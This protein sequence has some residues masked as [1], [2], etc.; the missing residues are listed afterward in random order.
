M[1]TPSSSTTGAS[2]PQ[3]EHV[4]TSP[5]QVRVLRIDPSSR[6]S[7]ALRLLNG[8][9]QRRW[10]QR[11][12][13]DDRERRT[14]ELGLAAEL[15]DAR[16]LAG[17]VADDARQRLDAVASRLVDVEGDELL[18]RR[19]TVA[20]SCVA[21]SSSLLLLALPGY[22]LVRLHPDA[23]VAYV[24]VQGCTQG[25]DVSLNARPCIRVQGYP[26]ISAQG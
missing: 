12:V 16:H 2:P 6:S 8:A 17:D 19:A 23:G 4:T 1:R 26:Y 7:G 5:G 11:L 13:D 22:R 24:S 9:L 25:F 21:P 14:D 20:V 10:V 18:R 3:P 15:E